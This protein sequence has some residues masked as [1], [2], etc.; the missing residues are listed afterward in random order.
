MLHPKYYGLDIRIRTG[1]EGISSFTNNCTTF[2][3]V[4]RAIFLSFQFIIELENLI[5]TCE[6]LMLKLKS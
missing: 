5:L 3:L 4:I 6:T 1:Q 2:A